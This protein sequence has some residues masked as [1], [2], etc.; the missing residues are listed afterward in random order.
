MFLLLLGRG[1]FPRETWLVE[2][3]SHHV[4]TAQQT[5]GVQ[6]TSRMSIVKPATV[7]NSFKVLFLLSIIPFAVVIFFHELQEQL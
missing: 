1:N 7:K 3:K 5:E 2:K 4:C 6:L